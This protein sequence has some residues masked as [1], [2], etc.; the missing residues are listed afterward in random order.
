MTRIPAW[1]RFRTGP[2]AMRS[3]SQWLAVGVPLLI[4]SSAAAQ[5]K[6]S[7]RIVSD[8]GGP[9][10]TLLLQ[11]TPAFDAPLH[12]IAHALPDA[13]L[14]VV[15]SEDDPRLAERLSAG[16]RGAVRVIRG[17]DDLTPWARDTFLPVSTPQGMR[18]LL[19]PLLAGVSARQAD[20]EVPYLVASSGLLT[21][22]PMV[23]RSSFYLEGG[24]LVSDGTH[25]FAGYSVVLDNYEHG[26]VPRHREL[27]RR[28]R[29]VTGAQLVIIGDSHQLPP[30]D[31]VDMYLTP[32][33]R[34]RVL[35]GDPTRGAA[36]VKAESSAQLDAWE[37]RFRRPKPGHYN[38]NAFSLKALLRSSAKRGLARRFDAVASQLHDAGYHVIRVPLLA[39]TDDS[40]P[41]LSYNNVLQETTTDSKV[42]VLPTY[43]FPKLDAAAIETWERL[44]YTVR[45]VDMSGIVDLQG[46]V[47]CLTQ[48]LHREPAENLRAG[49]RTR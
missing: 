10:R 9:I 44:G 42:V 11:Y 46:A 36:L 24:N 47:R 30:I 48:V 23:L 45:S 17:A 26:F 15:S 39:A 3:T 40:L 4:S 29:R 38:G 5:T 1:H 2:E 34:R 28:L 19:R 20:R 14:V 6:L 21:G 49:T 31:H 35:L 33:G 18:F 12:A 41:V 7:Q 8:V 13:D 22:E 27:L 16:R 25:A 32:L 37:E 43:G